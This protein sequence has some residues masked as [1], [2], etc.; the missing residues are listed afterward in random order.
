MTNG[1][2][3]HWFRRFLSA[4]FFNPPA[5]RPLETAAGLN[6]P[7]FDLRQG[8]AAAPISRRLLEARS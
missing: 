1:Q 3:P 6:W 8:A 4:R 7:M 2:V 5:G